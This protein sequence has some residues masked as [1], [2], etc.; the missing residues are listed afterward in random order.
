M[1]APDSKG[2]TLSADTVHHF[3][4]RRRSAPSAGAAVMLG[5]L[6]GRTADAIVIHSFGPGDVVREIFSTSVY[7]WNA[8]SWAALAL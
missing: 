3:S 4:R 5:N 8:F 1:S 6:L 2:T 7:A